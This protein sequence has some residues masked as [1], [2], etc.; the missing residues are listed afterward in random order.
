MHVLVVYQHN[1]KNSLKHMS[2]N[3][4]QHAKQELSAQLQQFAIRYCFE[5][6]LERLSTDYDQL[7]GR[8]MRVSTRVGAVTREKELSL[9]LGYLII[10]LQRSSCILSALRVANR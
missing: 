8:N 2:H 1:V 4:S 7:C 9:A 5:T 3:Q 10:T 6:S